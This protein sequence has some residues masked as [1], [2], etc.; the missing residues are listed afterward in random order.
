MP[1]KSPSEGSEFVAV[2]C[3][4]NL[5]PACAVLTPHQEWPSAASCPAPRGFQRPSSGCLASWN[6]PEHVLGLKAHLYVKLNR[7]T[8]LIYTLNGEK[9]GQKCK[10]VKET[11]IQMAGAAAPTTPFVCNMQARLFQHPNKAGM[12]SS[13]LCPK[14][15]EVF[16]LLRISRN[17][18]TQMMHK[19]G[20]SQAP[21]CSNIFLWSNW[22]P[23]KMW[24]GVLCSA[25]LLSSWRNV[26][27]NLS[28][29]S[30]HCF[31]LAPW[32]V[33]YN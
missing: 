2:S 16:A 17:S 14:L 13:T 8:P 3:S 20:A 9:S 27:L 7:Y 11:G 26:K 5:T 12:E 30:P 18:Q 6:L 21:S 23:C 29:L 15:E 33:R 25:L 10:K 1:Q 24:R 31:L 4:L 32:H 28:M 19:L 22:H